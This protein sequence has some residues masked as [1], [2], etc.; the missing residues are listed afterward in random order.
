MYDQKTK[1][2]GILNKGKNNQ[3]KDNVFDG[4]DVGIQDEGEATMASG[5]AFVGD[6]S[7]NTSLR[8][9]QTWWSQV[10]VGLIIAVSGG[11]VLN[12]LRLN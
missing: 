7:S 9:Y 3:F 10:V 1:K 11:F 6:K 12:L 4:L 5:N 8:W 2:I